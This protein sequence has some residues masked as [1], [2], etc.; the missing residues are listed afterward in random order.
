MKHE[1]I[2]S[3]G[4][5]ARD[6][7]DGE[8]KFTDQHVGKLI[9]FVH[10]QEWGKRTAIIIT[11]D[12][13]EGFGEHK[14]YRHGFELWDMLTHVPLLI[15][16]PG[17][18]PRRIDTP[19]SSIDLAPT[20]LELTGT[21]LPADPRFQGASLVPELYG[22]EPEPRD[23][24]IDLPRTSDNDRRRALIHDRYKLIAYGDDEAFALY[25]LV[26]DP[27]ETKDLQRDKTKKE[28]FEQ[29][30]ARYKER[31]STIKDIC[32]KMREKLKG[33]KKSKPC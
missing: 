16:A 12:H 24:I 5:K 32:P 23:V 20:I 27:G 3:F 6:L 21:P 29:M 25:D 18:K 28:A 17:V 11:A 15:Q 1:G 31:V 33:R 26:D 14:M 9:D 19:R 7:Y 10:A 13:G 22:K 30:M 2:E 4:K 8:M